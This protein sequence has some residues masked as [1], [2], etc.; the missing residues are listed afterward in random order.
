M[1]Y[2]ATLERVQSATRGSQF[3][4]MVLGREREYVLVPFC[5]LPLDQTFRELMVR[6]GYRFCGCM[7][8]RDGL[9]FAKGEPGQEAAFTIL[10]AAGAYAAY[11]AGQ[12]KPEGDGVSWLERL[13]ALVDPR[14]EENQ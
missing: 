13:H 6:H 1:D 9:T 8:Y 2:E 11:L 14:P 5:D 4:C 12:L 10:C 7:G 3:L